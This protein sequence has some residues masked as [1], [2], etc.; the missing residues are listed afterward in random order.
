[1]PI[2]QKRA[3]AEAHRQHA[4][5]PDLHHLAGLF[6]VHQIGGRSIGIGSAV[7]R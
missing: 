2:D 7:F 6:G 4:Q 5:G 1:M 3:T